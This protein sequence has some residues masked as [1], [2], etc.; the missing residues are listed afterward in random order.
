M[1][2]RYFEPDEKICLI[3]DNT[4]YERLREMPEYAERWNEGSTKFK[5]GPFVYG[6][7][8]IA[9]KWADDFQ[10]G[11]AEFDFSPH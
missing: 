1:V 9:S 10:E 5:S 11:I 6:D 4:D 7:L 2:G 8:P 3:F